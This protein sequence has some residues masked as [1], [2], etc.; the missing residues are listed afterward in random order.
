MY[1]HYVSLLS[2]YFN[3]MS[4]FAPAKRVKY[5]Y[6]NIEFKKWKTFLKINLKG[7][8]IKKSCL[9]LRSLINELGFN[10]YYSGLLNN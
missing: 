2:L 5:Y 1:C 10:K 8:L 6:W 9:P 7:L 3:T 4:I